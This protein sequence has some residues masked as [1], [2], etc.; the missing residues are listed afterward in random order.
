MQ[1]KYESLLK[2][3]SLLSSLNKE[4]L[5]LPDFSQSTINIY[6]NRE[7]KKLLI[8]VIPAIA[9]SIIMVIG[10]GFIKIGS[11]QKNTSHLAVNIANHN[12]AQK[13]IEYIRNFKGK[14]VLVNNSYID[15]EFDKGMQ[16][17]IE[18]T[19][20][21]NKIKHAVVINTAIFINPL[22][23]NI[24]NVA[25]AGPKITIQNDLNYSN[26]YTYI[27]NYQPLES[28]KVRIRIFK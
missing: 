13:F 19:L 23:K 24:H 8:K 6:K 27:N 11:F 5:A 1:K 28:G 18:T 21:K 16:K 15:T 9:A 17:D 2:C 10:I 20:H 7:R 4:N 25:F 3:K 22:E 12:D 26:N 14:V